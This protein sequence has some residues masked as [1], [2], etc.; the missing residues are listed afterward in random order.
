MDHSV[1]MYLVGPDGRFLT[2]YGYSAAADDIAQ[3]LRVRI[4][5]YN[6]EKAAAEAAEKAPAQLPAQLPAKA[7]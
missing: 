1:G 7:Q 2:K 4:E 5:T 3:R 6:A